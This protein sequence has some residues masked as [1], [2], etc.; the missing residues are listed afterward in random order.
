MVALYAGHIQ[1][2]IIG[3]GNGGKGQDRPLQYA[4]GTALLNGLADHAALH[5][6]LQAGGIHPRNAEHQRGDHALVGIGHAGRAAHGA[7][8]GGIAGGIHRIKA[9]QRKAFAAAAHLQHTFGVGFLCIIHGATVKQFY[10]CL[11]GQ[12]LKHQF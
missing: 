6:L 9:F 2:H 1:A 7:H 12:L 3:S 4:L 10:A 11:H 5:C 8:H